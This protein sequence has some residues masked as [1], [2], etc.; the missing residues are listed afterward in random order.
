MIDE[1]KV[2]VID[3][4]LSTMIKNMDDCFSGMVGQ[5]DACLKLMHNAETN[6]AKAYARCVLLV[7]ACVGM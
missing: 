2:N 5:G 1:A 3:K 4:R 7:F 6:T